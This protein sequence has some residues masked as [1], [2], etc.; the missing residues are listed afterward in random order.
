MES[1]LKLFSMSNSSSSSSSSSLWLLVHF[2]RSSLKLMGGFFF[3]VLTFE[4][5]LLVFFWPPW[6]PVRLWVDWKL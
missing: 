6:L 5:S 2:E 4:L 1:I 3:S